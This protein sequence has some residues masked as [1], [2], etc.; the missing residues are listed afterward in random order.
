MIA[1]ICIEDVLLDSAKEVFETMVFMDIEKA[2]E[3]ELAI[4]GSALLSSLTFDGKLKGCI[5]ICCSELCAADIASNMLGVS[6]EDGL[7]SDQVHDAFG[8]M[9]NMIMGKVELRLQEHYGL[10]Q[11]SIPCVTTG[12][13]LK[14]NLG[15]NAQRYSINLNLQ[16]MHLLSLSL[17]CREK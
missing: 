14:N 4:A 8:E 6:P 11:A 12:M 13:E 16:D 10:L 7:T 9:M 5:G 2:Q 1:N 15:N 17:I 3:Q